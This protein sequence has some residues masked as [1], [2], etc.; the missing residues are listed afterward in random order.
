MWFWIKHLS[1]AAILIFAAGYFLLGDGPMFKNQQNNAAASG[2]SQFYANIKSS[3]RSATERDKY[4]IALGTPNNNLDA[5]LSQRVG[6]V[7]AT[8]LRWQGS[9]KVR[10]F[11]AGATLKKAMSDFAKEEGVVFYWHLDKDYVIK[12][13]FRVDD[14]FVATLHQVGRAIDS[15]FESDV[16][17]FFCPQQRAAL[18]T[19]RP[20][21]YVRDNCI[22]TI[23]R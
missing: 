1:L 21:A 23:A 7:Q 9:V 3:V 4:V 20:S 22:K 2:L 18:I 11:S 19:E 5:Q 6:T 15:D 17:S 13:P 8:D 16:H 12:H 10:R 14:T